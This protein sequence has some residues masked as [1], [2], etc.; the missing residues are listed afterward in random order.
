MATDDTSTPTRLTDDER[1]EKLWLAF[2]AC[3]GAYT[4]DRDHD[5]WTR[6]DASRTRC[7]LLR[8]IVFGDLALTCRC[9]I[10]G[11]AASLKSESHSTGANDVLR[12]IAAGVKRLV[13]AA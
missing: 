1:L 4:P 6:L 9:F 11:S 2:T 5:I 3:W 7:W 12:S 8:L 13:G 10:T